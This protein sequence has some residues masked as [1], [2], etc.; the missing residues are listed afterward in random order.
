MIDL[1]KT[2]KTRD[3]RKVILHEIKLYNDC[4]DLVTYPVK[5]GYQ[6]SKRKNEFN[7]AIWSIDGRADVVWGTKSHLDLV[8]SARAGLRA[9]NKLIKEKLIV[10]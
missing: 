3:G 10:S 9:D 2:Y 5:G 1:N 4:G 7:Y 8:E 6:K